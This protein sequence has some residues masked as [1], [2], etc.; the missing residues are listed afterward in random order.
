LI[1]RETV[2]N[3]YFINEIQLMIGSHLGN[4]AEKFRLKVDALQDS[5]VHAIEIL[6]WQP[7]L[8]ASTSMNHSE[9][10]L[11]VDEIEGSLG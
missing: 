4:A 8:A 9:F 6:D 2:H 10:L 1:T 3:A 5:D 11:K 7:D